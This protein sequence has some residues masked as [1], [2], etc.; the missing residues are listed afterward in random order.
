MSDNMAEKLKQGL[1]SKRITARAV[2]TYVVF[3]AIILVFVLFGFQGRHSALGVGSAARVNSTFISIADFQ[4][5]EQR[6]Q[7]YYANLFGGIDL[8]GQRQMLRQQAIENLVRMEIVAQ[9]AKSE[10]ILATDAEIRDFIVK[11][12]PFFQQ[13]GQFKKDLYSRYLEATHSSP[14]DFESKLRKDILNLRSHHLFDIVSKPLAVEV[15][16]MKQL[17]ETKMNLSFASIDQSKAQAH[18]ALALVTE[19]NKKLSDKDFAARAE[20]EYKATESSYNQAEEVKASHILISAKDGDEAALKKAWDKISAIRK[21]AEKE[22]FGKLAAEVSEDPGS[23]KQKG[24]LG[25][26]GRGRM[27]PEFERAAFAL[28][29]GQ[30]SEPVKTQFGY[31]LIKVTEKKEAKT[32]SFEQV[33]AQVAAKLL[34]K[35]QFDAKIKVLDEA[36]AKSDE[37]AVMAVL[38]ELGV[39][40]EETGSFDLMG[41]SVP[42]IQSSSAIQV[43][44]EVSAAKPLLPRLIR[45]GNLKYVVKFKDS[46]KES[47]ENDKSVSAEMLQKRRGDGLY[48]SWL[49]QARRSSK[50]DV[51]NDIIR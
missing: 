15:A 9:N 42:K 37:S 10:G 32:T 13:E 3:G 4:N 31:H 25:F 11:D 41:D 30:L 22:D 49:G 24:D 46:K 2:T 47:A 21:R 44:S 23:K 6:I 19:A 40:W 50:I 38:K 7:Q 18:L 33:K 8:S 34:A 36:L 27:A 5:E 51:N 14:A 28:K 17:K 12:I 43:V 29:P 35:E 20:A 48:Q 45:E 39:S 16:K 26:F 1:T